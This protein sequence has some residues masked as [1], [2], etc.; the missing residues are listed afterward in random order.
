M[1]SIR[2]YTYSTVEEQDR[3]D[4]S[5]KPN[6]IRIE[7]AL[8]IIIDT[9]QFIEVQKIMNERKQTGKKSNYLCRLMYCECGAKMHAIKSTRK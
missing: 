2:V 1:K 6:A 3:T 7:N 8:P 5:S 4:R 9:A